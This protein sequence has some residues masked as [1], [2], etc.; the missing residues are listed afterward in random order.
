MVHGVGR[1]ASGYIGPHRTT[2]VT[3]TV[4]KDQLFYSKYCC[5]STF[6]KERSICKH[7]WLHVFKIWLHIHTGIVSI[8]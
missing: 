7:D 6:N 5:S 4:R 2:D 3:K 1:T 8:Q